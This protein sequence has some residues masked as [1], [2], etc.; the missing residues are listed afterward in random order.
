M[1]PP[2]VTA[3]VV[4]A[5]AGDGTELAAWPLVL[6]GPPD[7]SVVDALARL[8]LAAGRAGFSVSLDE[9]TPELLALLELVGLADVVPA[10]VAGSEGRRQPEVG[11]ELGVDEAVDGGDAVA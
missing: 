1:L 6:P 10:A 11:E 3:T 4:V 8:Q 7:L 2:E 9:A 5:R